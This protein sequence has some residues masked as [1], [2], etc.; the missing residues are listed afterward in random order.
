MCVCVCV[1]VCLC[2]CVCVCVCVCTYRDLMSGAIFTPEFS[3][4]FV[5]SKGLTSG[6]GRGAQKRRLKP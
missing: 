3:K 5:G 2:V 4:A 6:R 1:C